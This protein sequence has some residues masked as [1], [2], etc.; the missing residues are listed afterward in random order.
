M[1]RVLAL[2][3]VLLASSVN[4]SSRR[5]DEWPD[6]YGFW[7]VKVDKTAGKE[8]TDNRWFH[9]HDGEGD[10]G[11]TTMQVAIDHLGNAVFFD[12]DG[13]H[14]LTETQIEDELGLDVRYYVNGVP[15]SDWLTEWP[16]TFTL[17]NDDPDLPAQGGIYDLSLEVRTSGTVVDPPTFP[18][19]GCECDDRYDFVPYAAFLHLG[20][21]ASEKTTVPVL[22]QNSQEEVIY[23]I[24]SGTAVISNIAIPAMTGYPAATTLT[25]WT[26]TP[27]YSQTDLWQEMMQ[28]TNEQFAGIQMWWQEP[29]GTID[30][31]M[32]FVRSLQPKFSEF[33]PGLW[34]NSGSVANDAHGF[35]GHRGAPV[36]DGPRG[37]GWTSGY[38]QGA[39]EDVAAAGEA[40]NCFFMH[41]GGQLRVQRPDGEL[42]TIVGW[43]VPSGQGAIWN[44]KPLTSIRAGMEFRG[45]ITNGEWAGDSIDPWCHQGMD[46]AVN[47]VDPE[48]LYV[49]CYYDNAI[50]QVDLDRDTWTGTVSVLAGALDHSSGFTNGTGTAARFYH[51][52]SLVASLDGQYLYVSDQDNDA[53]RRIETATGVTTTFHS[54]VGLSAA[55]VGDPG[56]TC[57][58]DWRLTCFHASSV[59]ASPDV[60]LEGAGW[61]TYFPGFIRIDSHGHLVLFDFGLKTLRWIDVDTNEATIIEDVTG[62]G[63]ALGNGNFGPGV[64][65]GWVWGDVDRWGAVGP[66]NSVYWGNS[67]SLE[68]GPGSE[69]TGRF[70][71]DSRFAQIHDEDV[72]SWIFGQ[73]QTNRPVGNGPPGLSRPPHYP[74]FMAVD[75]NGALNISGIGSHG[76]TRVR[77]RRSSDP[78][79][80]TTLS[81]IE[82]SLER[83][84]RIN[85]A[86]GTR[87]PFSASGTYTIRTEIDTATPLQTLYGWNMHNMIGQ[88]DAWQFDQDSTDEE[89]DAAM[90]WP[91]EVANDAQTLAM[92]RLYARFH[93]NSE[94]A[95]GEP[96]GD[97]PPPATIRIPLRIRLSTVLPTLPFIGIGVLLVTLNT[98][99]DT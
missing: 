75:P 96:P 6:P 33:W 31:G 85:F 3:L 27:M 56:V 40:N 89:I 37:V 72:A 28:P 9:L 82:N 94:A 98:R 90:D 52:F 12:A 65:W 84:W 60:T 26:A 39:C 74:W 20:G 67:T 8:M 64:G 38:I 77:K 80:A 73:S 16:Y 83:D 21:R 44:L 66:Q 48:V 53:I 15:V 14:G 46:V 70:N 93:A 23:Q 10:A 35:G 57:D 71:E 47:P 2:C 91:A 18:P 45:T 30:A 5:G 81:N 25:R 69:A 4:V 24:P 87:A 34:N 42:I 11:E 22:T 63:G 59:R 29:A 43:R 51:P 68:P 17:E 62:N 13:S 32:L 78:T 49:A 7:A 50:Y 55:L 1:R 86:G 41:I 19:W 97:P 79:Y 99:R 88:P 54:T 58:T 95:L 61:T 92:M 76:I 36:R